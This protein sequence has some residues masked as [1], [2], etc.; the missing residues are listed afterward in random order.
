MGMALL[1]WGGLKKKL[2]PQRRKGK[3]KDAKITGKNA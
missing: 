2:S 1:R 3:R